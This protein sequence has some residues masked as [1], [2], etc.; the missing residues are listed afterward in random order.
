MKYKK[1]LTILQVLPSLDSGGVERGTIEIASYLAKKKHNSFVLSKGGRLVNNLEKNGSTHI[2][3]NIGKKSLFSLLLIP[4]LIKIFKIL[5]V[6]IV[7]ARSRFPAWLVFI[8][9]KFIPKKSR[10][11]FVCTVH[12]FNS[13]SLYS[14]IML[15]GDKV[16]V[17]SNAVKKYMIDNYDVNKSKLNLIY[18]GVPLN[19]NINKNSIEYKNWLRNWKKTY[20]Q[21]QSKKIL[22]FP[23]RLSRHKGVEDFLELIKKLK[24]INLKVVGL[25][26]GEAK[27]KNYLD[28]ITRAIKRLGIQNEI[29]IVGYSKDIYEIISV[30]KIV[31]AIQKVPE[32]FGRIVIESIKIGTPVIGYNHGGVSEQLSLI[33]PDGLIDNGDKS[34]LFNKTLEFLSKKPL[35]KK[36]KKFSLEEMQ[37]KTLKLYESFY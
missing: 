1:K 35:V 27:S 28:E 18:R 36:T 21:I 9:L 7:H 17:V 19:L 31:Y 20:P 24:N 26:V 8:S 4:K 30:S 22:L 23:S 34:K 15:K 11:N 29:I 37:K 2:Q 6:D 12:G 13:I 33:F 25:I 16:I 3:M 14:S 10:P 5:D 32:S